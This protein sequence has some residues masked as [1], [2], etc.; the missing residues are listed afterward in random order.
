[1]CNLL[2]FIMFVFT[3]KLYFIYNDEILEIEYE[4]MKY[5]QLIR[6]IDEYCIDSDEPMKIEVINKLQFLRFL[7]FINIEIEIID[8]NEIKMLIWA[9][10]FFNIF[11]MALK[12]ALNNISLYVYKFG[13]IFLN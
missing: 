3:K 1:M 12:M 5:C 6:D 4:I 2:I 11:D 9:S 10:D 7:D 8:E 13:G